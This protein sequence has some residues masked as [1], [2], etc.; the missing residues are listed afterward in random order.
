VAVKVTAGLVRDD[1][2]PPEVR[3]SD[4]VTLAR[5][6]RTN[7]ALSPAIANK[8]LIATSKDLAVVQGPKSVPKLIAGVGA[9]DGI[10]VIHLHVPASR[11]P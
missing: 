5:R 4:F 9:N 11:A 6:C 2:G 10:E 1:F 8:L 3:F 7:G